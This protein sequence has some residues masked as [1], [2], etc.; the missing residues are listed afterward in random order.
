MVKNY[1]TTNGFGWNLN[2]VVGAQIVSLPVKLAQTFTDKALRTILLW[3]GGILVLVLVAANIIVL[4]ISG[5]FKTPSVPQ[6][7]SH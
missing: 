6:S 4:L 2:E 5:G 1:G 7:P 3:L